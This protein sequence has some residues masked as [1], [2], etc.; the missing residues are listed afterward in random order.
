MTTETNLASAT[1]N[2]LTDRKAYDIASWLYDIARWLREQ[3]EQGRPPAM[4]EPPGHETPSGCFDFHQLATKEAEERIK[5]WHKTPPGIMYDLQ[6]WVEYCIEEHS[7]PP[8]P[9]T[10]RE[11]TFQEEMNSLIQQAINSLKDC[12]DGGGAEC[13]KL[14][15]DGKFFFFVLD[16]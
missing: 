9:P 8:I 13:Q 15:D 6:R 10:K 14:I 5:R 2:A 11:K 7:R 4:P 12:P 16:A 1:A 3:G